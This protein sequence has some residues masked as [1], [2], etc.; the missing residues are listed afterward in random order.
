MKSFIAMM[1]LLCVSF[2]YTQAGDEYE[3]YEK[4]EPTQM[5]DRDVI[6][7]NHSLELEMD[8]GMVEAEW[9]EFS[10]DGF[11]WF[12]LVY[13]TTNSNPVYPEDKTIFVGSK[14]QRETTFRLDSKSTNH[15]VRLCAV[16]LN[17]DYS[18]D[19]YCGEVQ[20]LVTTAE[21][22]EDDSQEEKKYEY[23]KEVEA[24]TQ[25]KKEELQKKLEEKKRLIAEKKES[26]TQKVI[27]KKAIISTNM[28]SRI[29]SVIENFVSKLEAK[30][31]SDAQMTSAIN[32]VISRL[33]EFKNKAWYTEIVK[34]MIVV[35]EEYRDE[36][37]NPLQELESI[38][39]GL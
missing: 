25:A 6:Y 34:Y 18:K 29:D 14:D 38:F 16:V 23:K 9:D 10:K 30:W 39:D 36:Y 1:L 37:S 3:K 24:K 12:K 28:K 17:D 27:E 19:R 11:D 26:T 22:F 7:Y 31:Y 8:D 33:W 15:Y 2:S 4:T 21:D 5:E 20:K 32:T 35:L 13:S